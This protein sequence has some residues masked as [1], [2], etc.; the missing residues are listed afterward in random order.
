MNEHKHHFRKLEKALDKLTLKDRSGFVSLYIE[1][2]A[3]YQSKLIE[4]R[5]QQ[6][7]QEKKEFM[8]KLRSLCPGGVVYYCGNG[9]LFGKEV[10]LK[11]VKRTWLIGTIEGTPWELH[12]RNIRLDK[13]DNAEYRLRKR[14]L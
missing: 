3:K 8:K 6:L 5:E 2:K 13:P 14:F 12:I 9:N 7:A 11:K 10:T 1:F 4:L